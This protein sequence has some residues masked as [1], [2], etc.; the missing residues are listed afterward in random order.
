MKSPLTH[1]AAVGLEMIVFFVN[2]SF[3]T[4]KVILITVLV[5]QDGWNHDQQA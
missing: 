4:Y 1:L 5:S 2:L 3:L